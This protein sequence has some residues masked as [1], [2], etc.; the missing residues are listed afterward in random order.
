MIE[1]LMKKMTSPRPPP[2]FRRG[3]QGG[4]ITSHLVTKNCQANRNGY[5][6]YR[7]IR[8]DLSKYGYRRVSRKKASALYIRLRVVWLLSN[9]INSR[10]SA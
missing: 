5:S 6:D 2:G 4:K 1:E 10:I 9:P 7:I 3:R 8:M